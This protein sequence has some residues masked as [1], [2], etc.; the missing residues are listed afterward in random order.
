MLKHYVK[1][2]WELDLSGVLSFLAISARWLK[3]NKEGFFADKEAYVEYKI[4]N[5]L[6]RNKYRKPVVQTSLDIGFT[7]LDRLDENITLDGAVFKCFKAN[8]NSSTPVSSWTKG[9]QIGDEIISK[10]GGKFELEGIKEGC[11]ILEETKAPAGYEL[12]QEA[13][14]WYISYSVSDGITVF[15]SNGKKFD[16]KNKFPDNAISDYNYCIVNSKVYKL[17]K[18]GGMGTYAFYLTG[19]FILVISIIGLRR[20]IAA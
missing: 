8:G 11:Y 14:T 12:Q 17:P 10:N 4:A 6:K 1:H 20:K 9:T 13:K 7:K 16:E 15:D 18:A 19:S 3:R 2:R 5:E